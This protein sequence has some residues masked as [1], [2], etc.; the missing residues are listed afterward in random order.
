MSHR[1]YRT[2]ISDHEGPS[3]AAH[4]GLEALTVAS[5]CITD[6]AED[7]E[8]VESSLRGLGSTT[9]NQLRMA[10]PA[11]RS[12]PLVTC[13]VWLMELAAVVT[14]RIR[15]LAQNSAAASRSAEL[16]ADYSWSDLT[17]ASHN[18]KWRA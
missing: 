17:T 4:P 5:D 16:V 7:Q 14:D 10:H 11:S 1:G 13:S 12:E 9:D 3:S 2:K 8:N 15:R 6:G 18:S